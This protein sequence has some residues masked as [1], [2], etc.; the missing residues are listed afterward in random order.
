M[1]LYFLSE[2]NINPWFSLLGERYEVF[3]PKYSAGDTQNGASGQ[4]EKTIFSSYEGKIDWTVF[5]QIRSSN[6]LKEFFFL[7][8]EEVARYFKGNKE[9]R[10]RKV[11]VIIGAKACDILPLRVHQK[12]FILKDFSDPFF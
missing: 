11:R 10:E 3:T 7:A 9:G 8:R 6:P 12:M 4:K 5:S 2:R 1:A